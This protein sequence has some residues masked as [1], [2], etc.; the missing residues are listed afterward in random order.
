MNVGFIGCGNIANYHAEVLKALDINILAVSARENS[1]NIS[2]FSE[3]YGI[4]HQYTRWQ[5]I[6]ENESL[7]ALWVVVSWEQM[8]ALLIPLIETGIPLFLE[9]P[10]ALSSENMSQ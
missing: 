1:P 8:D 9:K 10:V 5:E 2:S 7:D 4:Q 6:V 3:K